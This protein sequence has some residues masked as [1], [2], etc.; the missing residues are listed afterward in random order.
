MNHV[1]ALSGGK[2]STAM[3]LRLR[4]V[5]PDTPFLYV[6]TPTGD[7]LPEMV[8]HWATLEKMLDAPIIQVRHSLTLNGLIE[9]FN[10]LPNWRQRWC[11]RMLKIEPYRAWLLKHLPAI[12]Y[13]GLRADERERNGADFQN[14]PNVEVCFPM[15]GW[16]WSIKEVHRYLDQRGVTIPER[17]DCGKCFFQTL[18]EWQ[19]LWENYAPRYAEAEGYENATGHTFRSPSRDKWPAALKDMR[20]E[21]ERGHF[22]EPQRDLFAKTKCRVCSL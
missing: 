17:T 2:D 4:E 3:A 19:S 12:S 18:G 6:C 13:V 20:A 7:E 16:G 11:T 22:P 21:F 8:E 5:M 1:V 15:R 14:I 10:A 9:H